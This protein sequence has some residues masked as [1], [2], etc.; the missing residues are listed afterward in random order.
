MIAMTAHI[1]SKNMNKVLV[2][3]PV[4]DKIEKL[5]NAINMIPHYDYVIFNGGLCYPNSN[6]LEV[7]DRLSRMDKLIKTKKVI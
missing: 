4:Y 5:H 1:L 3:G 2:V 7:K 6:L